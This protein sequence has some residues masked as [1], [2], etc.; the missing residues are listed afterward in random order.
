MDGPLIPTLSQLGLIL[1]AVVLA[2][3]GAWMLMN[4]P[5]RSR[6]DDPEAR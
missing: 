1:L 2:G 6:S 3:A 5:E 4:R